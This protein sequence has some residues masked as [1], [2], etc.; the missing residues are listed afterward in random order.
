MI[1]MTRVKWRKE[2]REEKMISVYKTESVKEN[3]PCEANSVTRNL[4]FHI[5]VYC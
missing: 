5:W 1:I 2:K 3:H 4:V